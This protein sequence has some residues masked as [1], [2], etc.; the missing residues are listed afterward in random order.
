MLNV[1]DIWGQLDSDISLSDIS[2][3]DKSFSDKM[4]NSTLSSFDFHA[5]ELTLGLDDLTLGA[6]TKKVKIQKIMYANP[7]NLG[8]FVC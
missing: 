6:K 5:K 3:S 1:R 2:F 8:G 4:D 7:V